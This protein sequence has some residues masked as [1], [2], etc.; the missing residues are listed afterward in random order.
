M[1]QADCESGVKGNALEGVSEGGKQGDWQCEGMC[2]VGV[3]EGK[4]DSGLVEGGNIGRIDG[5]KGGVTEG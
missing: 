3:Y 1:R 5:E 2:F 4:K